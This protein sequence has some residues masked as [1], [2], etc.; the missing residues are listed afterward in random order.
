MAQDG[1]DD[2]EVGGALTSR[3]DIR[4]TILHELPRTCPL[5]PQVGTDEQLEK[6]G[7]VMAIVNNVVVVKGMGSG[8]HND[9]LRVG[10]RT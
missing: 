2:E 5:I 4:V 9:T 7:E 3:Q 10:A 8:T 6:V 1:G